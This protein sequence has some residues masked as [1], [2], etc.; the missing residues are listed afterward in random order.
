MKSQPKG[1]KSVSITTLQPTN[2]LGEIRLGRNFIREGDTVKVLPSRPGKRDGFVA[3]FLYAT[4]NEDGS[5]NYVEVL[6]AP[7]GRCPAWRS[8]P[9]ERIGRVSQT[10]GGEK[11][12]RTRK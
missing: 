2:R 3:K 10:K 5:I 1:K 4:V 7:T 9:V 6:G 12:E 8:L 11:V